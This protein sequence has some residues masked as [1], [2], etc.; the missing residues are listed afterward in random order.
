MS[1]LVEGQVGEGGPHVQR[2]GGVELDQEAGAGAPPQAKV[3][4]QGLHAQPEGQ[5]GIQHLARQ[6][7]LVGVWS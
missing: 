3:A 4:R 5:V 2:L 6:N 7:H 1:A